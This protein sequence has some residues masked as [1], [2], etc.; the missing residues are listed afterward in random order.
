MAAQRGVDKDGTRDCVV[1]A[2]LGKG[3]L[4]LFVRGGERLEISRIRALAASHGLDLGVL[5]A[6]PRQ[7]RG[8][9]LSPLDHNL[10]LAEGEEK[11]ALL[12]GEAAPGRSRSGRGSRRRGSLRSLARK[13][14]KMIDC[15]HSH[16][17]GRHHFVRPLLCG[18]WWIS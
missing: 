17:R 15:T 8:S 5:Q 2:G 9:N 12:V 11:G 3:S 10:R 14:L 1:V 18:P 16:I 4:V 13:S 7:H 6:S